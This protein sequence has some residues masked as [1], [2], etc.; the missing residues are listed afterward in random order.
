MNLRVPMSQCRDMGITCL[1]R[2]YQAIS[3]SPELEERYRTGPS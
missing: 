1:N 2:R 3:S